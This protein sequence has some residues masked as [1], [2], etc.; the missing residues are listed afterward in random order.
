MHLTRRRAL[1]I[2]LGWFNDE[3]ISWELP[4]LFFESSPHP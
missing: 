2:D 1:F 4:S 3:L